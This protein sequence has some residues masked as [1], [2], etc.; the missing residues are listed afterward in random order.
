MFCQPRGHFGTLFWLPPR[1]LAS[2]NVNDTVEQAHQGV[3]QDNEEY[4]Q[5]EDALGLCIVLVQLCIA[6]KCMFT[7]TG[8]IKSACSLRASKVASVVPRENARAVFL[9]PV[10][11]CLWRH[12]GVSDKV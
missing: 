1:A 6:W 5:E 4:E 3:R 7:I 2:T 12:V 11:H 9:F 8:A 10:R